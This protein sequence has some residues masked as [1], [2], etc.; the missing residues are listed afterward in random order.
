MKFVVKTTPL[1]VLNTNDL[2]SRINTIGNIQPGCFLVTMDVNSLY[3]NMP[4]G[5]GIRALR[6]HLDDN[7][8]PS[9]EVIIASTEFILTHNYFSF[10]DEI[11]IF[12]TPQYA[13]LFM[14]TLEEDFLDSCTLKPLCYP[15]Y[16]DDSSHLTLR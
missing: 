16:I 2:L 7:N 13:T 6:S 14:S 10:R 12:A 5:D 1:F 9:V 3:T 15:R 11:Y 4:H 8:C